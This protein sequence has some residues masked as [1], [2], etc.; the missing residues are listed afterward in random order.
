MAMKQFRTLSVVL[1]TAFS[2]VASACS[3]STPQ[4]LPEPTLG[5]PVRGTWEGTDSVEERAVLF[6]YS[7][8]VGLP[9]R[10]AQVIAEAAGWDVQ[11]LFTQV[12][13]PVMMTA[14]FSWSRLRFIVVDGRVTEVVNS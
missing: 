3:A 14:D 10:Q 1:I 7:D 8:L 5:A 13:E 6:G 4:P 12:G 11:L 2:L 9:Y